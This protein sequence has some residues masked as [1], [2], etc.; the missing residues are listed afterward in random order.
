M[1]NHCGTAFFGDEKLARFIHGYFGYIIVGKGF[2]EV[3]LH[4]PV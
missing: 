1:P 4:Y 2:A 3:I